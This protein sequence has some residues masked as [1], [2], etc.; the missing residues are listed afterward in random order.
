MHS[1]DLAGSEGA[2]YFKRFLPALKEC[3]G[4]YIGTDRSFANKK[5][6]VEMYHEW[7]E[8]CIFLH[9]LF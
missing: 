4:K 3:L 5:V 8:V 6:I 9:R 1:F 7:L 2:N